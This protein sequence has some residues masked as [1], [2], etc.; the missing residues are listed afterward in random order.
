MIAHSKSVY[1][2]G[3]HSYCSRSKNVDGIHIANVEAFVCGNLHCVKRRTKDCGVRFFMADMRG[4]NHT[5]KTVGNPSCEIASWIPP[6]ELLITP[7]R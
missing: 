2:D 7:R 5:F 6:S 1:E 3:L 4:I